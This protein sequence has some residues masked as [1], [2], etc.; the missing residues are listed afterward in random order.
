M[1]FQTRK[2]DEFSRIV[3]VHKERKTMKE[4]LLGY[5]NVKIRGNE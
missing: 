4:L 3:S 2:L 5:L 1:E